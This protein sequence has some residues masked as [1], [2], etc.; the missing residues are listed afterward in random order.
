MHVFF[1]V[2]EPSGDQHTAHLIDELRTRIPNLQ[3][4]GFGGPL[5]EETGFKSHYRLTDL[6]VMGFFRVIPLLW[7]FYTLVR[8]AEQI[9]QEERPQVG[10]L[11]GNPNTSTDFPGVQSWQGRRCTR[12]DVPDPL[13]LPVAS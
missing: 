4:S 3:V 11:V 7:R 13:I 1:S 5:M 2:G 12:D 8:K 10:V 9:L 6:A